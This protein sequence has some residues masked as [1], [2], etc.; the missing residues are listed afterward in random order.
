MKPSYLGTFTIHPRVCV[1]H[2]TYDPNHREARVRHNFS[3]I[4]TSK[5]PSNIFLVEKKHTHHL[6]TRKYRA[7]TMLNRSIMY[8]IKRCISKLN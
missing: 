8:K 5:P 2:G 6:N 3:K 1:M 7:L 4:I